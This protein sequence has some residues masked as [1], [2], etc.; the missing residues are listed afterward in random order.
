MEHIDSFSHTGLPQHT[1][2]VEI[3]HSSNQPYSLQQA[4]AEFE[5]KFIRNVLVANDWD[6]ALTAKMLDIS[7]ETLT[8]K[9]RQY[10]I[11]PL[12]PYKETCFQG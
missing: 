3:T 7:R 10:G 11:T 6:E 4:V 8:Q 2:N 9:L 12:L 1:E 5:R